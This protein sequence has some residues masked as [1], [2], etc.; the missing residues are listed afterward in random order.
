[1]GNETAARRIYDYFDQ[2]WLLHAIVA[3]L[4]ATWFI[5]V[6]LSGRNWGMLDSYNGLTIRGHF[7][8][9][10]LLTLSVLY[11]LLK[12]CADSYDKKAKVK[13][14]YMFQRLLTCADGVTSEK[15]KR[16]EN[17]LDE[18]SPGERSA[19]FSQITQP[20]MQIDQL[21]IHAQKAL[22]DLFGI[23]VEDIGLSVIYKLP[24][25]TEWKCIARNTEHD[26]DA[27]H[28]VSQNASTLN[29]LIAGK[30]DSIFHPSKKTAELKGEYIMSPRDKTSNE[31]GSILCRNVS[32]GPHSRRMLA[33]F[34]LTTYGKELC[35]ENDVDSRSKIQTRIVDSIEKRLR[36]ELC[37]LYLRES[38]CRPCRNC[39]GCSTLKES[40]CAI[41]TLPV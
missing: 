10:P 6:Q 5:I 41:S 19:P 21:F 4:P 18:Y 36:L 12:H 17:F 34:S 20:K 37:L 16:F 38:L 27:Q 3:T 28:V 31:T 14:Q 22:A 39:C 32:V 30:I 25:A 9:W 7:I 15:L 23:D 24:T 11:T 8:T 13:G 35:E 2:R 1:M 40:Q 29:K 26:L 33:Y